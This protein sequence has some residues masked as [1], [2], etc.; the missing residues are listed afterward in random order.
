MPIG[1]IGKKL[2][3][4]RLF[5]ENGEAIPVT[6][7]EVGPCPVIQVKTSDTADAYAA[8]RLGFGEVEEK[9]VSKPVLGQFKKAGVKPHRLVRE[10]RVDDPTTFTVGQVLNADLFAAGE[11]VDVI[12]VSKGRGFQ[13]TI[14]RFRNHRGPETHGSMYHRRPGSGGGSSDP[15]RV[16]KGKIMPGHMGNERST[17]QNLKVVKTDVEKNLVLV[18]GSVPGHINSYVMVAKAIKPMQVAAARAAKKGA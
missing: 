2:G 15:S 17:A 4:T 11:K 6:V 9:K 10:F 14:K 18:R 12:G 1:L 5:D 16:Y 3:M 8:I 7:L 13:G